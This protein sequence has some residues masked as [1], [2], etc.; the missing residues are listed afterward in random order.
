[1][2]QLLFFAQI[3]EKVGQK[4]LEVEANG[5]TVKEIKDVFLAK[6]DIASLL[7]DAMVAINEEYATETDVVQSGDVVA[8]IPPVSGG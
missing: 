6:Y 5:K 2:V 8:F 7:E 1:M 3:Q 4:Q